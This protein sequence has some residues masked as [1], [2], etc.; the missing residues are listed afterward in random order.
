MLARFF[1]VI[2]TIII[3]LIIINVKHLSQLATAGRLV[4]PTEPFSQN[5]ALIIAGKTDTPFFCFGGD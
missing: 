2:I 4:G 1:Y 3:I 5:Q